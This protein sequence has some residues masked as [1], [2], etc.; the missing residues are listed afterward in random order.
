MP[1]DA[2]WN[3]SNSSYSTLM[4]AT[5]QRLRRAFEGFQYLG[6]GLLLLVVAM[7]FALRLFPPAD[8]HPSVHRRLL[9]LVPAGAVL[10]LLAISHEVDWAGRTLFTIPVPHAVI[11]SLD[12]LRASGRLFWPVAY[13]LVFAAV[14]AA[15]RLPRRRAVQLLGA[16]LVLQLADLTTMMI[17]VRN[18][19]KE[20]SE[21]R[22][23]S[24]VQ[25]PRWVEAIAASRDI[26]FV[27]PDVTTDLHL[28]QEVA[29]RAVLAGKP[30]RVVYAARDSHAT[31]TRLDGEYTAF[32]QG[33]LAPDRLYVLFPQ[34]QVPLTAAGRLR[35]L[36]GVRVLVPLSVSSPRSAS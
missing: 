6:V 27:P 18:I 32:R 31:L 26:T 7:P 14:L 1:L 3:P 12:P 11:S 17:A 2:L 35:V 29:W 22:T 10:T 30:V 5:E 13:V 25:D 16:A 33:R 4:P 36:N 21:R 15:F 20:A 9:W 34:A 23:Y 28:F 24:R 19:T 8:T